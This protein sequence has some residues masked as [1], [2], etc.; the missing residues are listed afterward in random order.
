M[1]FTRREWISTS[2][3]TAGALSALHFFCV[4][5]LAQEK[6]ESVGAILDPFVENYMRTM[7][8]PG[9]TLVLADRDGTQRITTYGFSD[10]QSRQH[11]EPNQ[12]FE[13]GSI[14]KSFVALILLQMRDEGKLDLNHTIT[15]Y[16]PWLK[17]D[18]GF[19]PITVH[20]FLTHTSGLP[21][22]PLFL[23]DPAAKHHAASPPGEDF[24]YNNMAFAALGHLIETI[25]GQAFATSLRKRIFEP[26]GMTESEPIITFD[27]RQ[28]LAKSYVPFL[29]DRPYPQQGPLCE[30]PQIVMTDTA[31]CIASTPRDMGLY[32]HM[33]A[34]SGRTKSGRIVSEESF[35]LFSKP[36]I[37]AEEFSPTASYG[38]GIAVDTLDGHKILRH[39]GGMVSFASA[40]QVDL[41]SGVGAFASINAMQGYRPNPVAQ[42]ALQLMRA[43]NERKALPP[44]QSAKSAR[45]IANASDFAGT[46]TTLEGRKL[47]FTANA[48]AVYVEVDGSRVQ[49]E[50]KEADKLLLAGSKFLYVFGRNDPKDPKSQVVEMGHGN[51][52]YTNDRYSGPKLFKSPP[53]W[54]AYLGHYRSENVW[55]G[56]FRIV[57]RKGVLMIDGVVPLEPGDGIFY[58]RD[59]P[60]SPEWISFHDIVNGKAMRVK[61]S[62][63]DFW[64]VE[65]D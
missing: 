47:Q 4:S 26:L 5:S 3:R 32:I 41:E 62:G 64:R 1:P 25:D 15:A 56:S 13:I 35:A 44:A 27:V 11:V 39:T 14:T 53:E 65:A 37:K 30:A 24:H 42:R 63:D 34:N 18:S 31:G 16:L 49:L 19:A 57:Q 50:M 52:R 51:D 38:Y 2:I 61:L 6:Y 46:Y 10:R 58:L 29:S 22:S 21:S 55:D 60:R 12:L 36:Y 54:W 23:S 28:R 48:D 59:E 45:I 9:M 17:I 8:A 40:L 33:L 20:H 43:V 7:N